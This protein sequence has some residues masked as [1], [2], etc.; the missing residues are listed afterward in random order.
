MSDAQHHHLDTVGSTLTE[1]WAMAERG[2]GIPFWL[3]ANRQVAGRGRLDRHWVSEAGNLYSTYVGPPPPEAA[4]PLLPFML[5]LA[6]RQA[7]LAHIPVERHARVQLKWP[8]DVLIGGAKISGVLVER[9]TLQGSKTLQEGEALQ[10]RTPLMAIGIGINVE[11]APQSLDRAVTSLSAQGG[12]AGPG[13]LFATLRAAVADGLETLARDP[14]AVLE[15][16]SRHAIGLGDAITVDL[17]GER[18]SGT[19]DHLAADGAL[20]LRLPSGALRSLHA[21]DVIHAALPRET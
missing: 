1:A 6:V 9:R 15:S 10:E 7:I 13:E 14:Q 19:F 8:N 12:T 5:S 16:W 11:H 4:F 17:G 18:V 3:T 20:V 21:G 2:Q